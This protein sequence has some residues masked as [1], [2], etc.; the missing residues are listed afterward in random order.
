MGPRDR[1]ESEPPP[2]PDPERA[3]RR[4]ESVIP[5]LIKKAVIGGVERGYA[6]AESLREFISEQKLPKEIVNALFSQIDETKNGLFRVV[7]KEIRNFLEAVDWQRELQKLLTTVSFE[8]K[9]EIRFIPND[10]TPEKLGRPEV[11]AGMRVKRNDIDE[12]RRKKKKARR[13]DESESETPETTETP[14]PV[15]EVSTSEDDPHERATAPDRPG[16]KSEEPAD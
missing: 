6:S 4:L 8:I 11:K 1:Y 9:T 3:R 2:P 13:R 12:E 7:A 5:D 14:P 10:S 15:G 16:A